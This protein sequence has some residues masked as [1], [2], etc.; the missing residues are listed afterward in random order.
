MAVRKTRDKVIYTLT[1]EMH[2]LVTELYEASVDNEKA[3]TGKAL[4]KL[5]KAIK[6][7]KSNIIITDE[8]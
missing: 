8:V 7:F 2:G 1:D 6:H 3:N 4:D 5:S